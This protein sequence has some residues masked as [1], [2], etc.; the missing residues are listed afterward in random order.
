[1]KG[2]DDK[3]RHEELIKWAVKGIEAEMEELE[4]DVFKGVKLLKD[5]DEGKPIKSPKNRFEIAE[6]VSQKR[7]QMEELSKVRAEL[8]WE[9]VE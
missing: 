9:L 5:I 2:E 7:Q 6:I 4:K 8:Q 3:M 1:M